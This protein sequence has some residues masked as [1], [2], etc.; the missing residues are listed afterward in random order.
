[1]VHPPSKE[2]QDIIDILT[3]NEFDV[4]EFYEDAGRG[5]LKPDVTMEGGKIDKWIEVQELDD[6][7]SLDNREYLMKFCKDHK[8]KQSGWGKKDPLEKFITKSSQELDQ[9]IR[10]STD[11]K[12]IYAARMSAIEKLDELKQEQEKVRNK[13][14]EEDCE[15]KKKTFQSS[16]D[17]IASIIKDT[18]ITMD[19]LEFDKLQDQLVTY[20]QEMKEHDF[21]L[22]RMRN[23]DAY[24]NSLNSEKRIELSAILQKAS[25]QHIIIQDDQTKQL[26]AKKKKEATEK[27]HA[28]R[29]KR[30]QRRKENPQ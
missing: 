25:E 30:T 5:G 13:K 24:I 20:K 29:L 12:V 27:R 10:S 14:N 26:Q 11:Q 4:E 17:A 2:Q 1:M 3:N 28:R 7:T 22:E 18:D 6:K 9:G 19:N 23:S 16:L 8:Y 21:S 15:E